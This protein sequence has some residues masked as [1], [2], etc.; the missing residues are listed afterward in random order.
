VLGKGG[1]ETETSFFC[2]AHLSKFHLKAETIQS[3]KRRVLSKRQ[4]DG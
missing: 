2:W 1:P 4:D 3:P